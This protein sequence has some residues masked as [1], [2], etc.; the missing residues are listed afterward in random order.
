LDEAPS[1]GPPKE[2]IP[3]VTADGRGLTGYW[4]PGREASARSIA[5]LAGLAAPQRYLHA[6]AGYLARCG[7]GV[8]TFD[9]RSVGA[10]LDPSSDAKVAADDW[11]NLDLPAA[12]AE[13]RRRTGTR[14]LA[15][16]AHSIGGQLLGQSPI[17]EEIDAALLIAAQRGSPALF[18]GVARLRVQYAYAVFPPL[19]RVLGYLPASPLTLPETCSGRALRQWARWGR[20]GVFTDENGTN[21]EAR[22][23]EYR[24][25][26]TAVS[27]A[28]DGNYAPPPAVDALTRLYTGAAVV[29]ESVRPGDFGLQSL[30]HLG[31]F[32]PRA[33]RAL[34]DRADAWLRAME[35]ATA[36]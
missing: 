31:F 9:Y 3:I 10:S 18:E 34:W 15:V 24:R 30:G 7:W 27:I 29:R 28:D 8:L 22:F 21:V 17:R 1:P 6:F 13:V 4:W 23:A 12:V 16:M 19:I 36:A 32:N 5:F 33:P 25:P 26:L 35:P 11:V 14:V 2:R 20:T